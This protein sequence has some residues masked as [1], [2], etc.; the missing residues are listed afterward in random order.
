MKERFLSLRAL[1]LHF[2]LILWLAMCVTAAWWQVGRAAS[3][4]ALSYLYAIEWPVFA[5]LGVVGWWGLL[6]IEKP[7]EEEEAARREYEEK[8]RLEAAAARVVDAVFEPEDD[9][10]AAYNNYLAG[11]AE[12]PHKGA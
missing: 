3:G 11:L 8:M 10:L 5:V 1:G 4:N 7:T 9:T 2:S 6:H 12:P